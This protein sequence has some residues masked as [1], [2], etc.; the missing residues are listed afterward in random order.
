MFDFSETHEHSVQELYKLQN[1]K[2]K[3]EKEV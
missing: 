3:I 1:I 2:S